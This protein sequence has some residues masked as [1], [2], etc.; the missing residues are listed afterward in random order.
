[1]TW[2]RQ[3]NKNVNMRDK[4]GGTLKGVEDSTRREVLEGA[5]DS[6][7]KSLP[8]NEHGRKKKPIDSKATEP[9]EVNNQSSFLQGWRRQRLQ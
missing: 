8:D 4:K 2:D 6:I 7:K 3:T 9:S 5:E 1:M